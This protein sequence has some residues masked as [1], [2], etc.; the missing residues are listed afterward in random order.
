MKKLPCCNAYIQ[1]AHPGKSDEQQR[2]KRDKEGEIETGRRPL[3]EV[4]IAKVVVTIRVVVNLVVTGCNKRNLGLRS[5]G[6]LVTLVCGALLTHLLI[7]DGGQSAGNLLDL[8]AGEFLHEL[9]GEVLRPEG[10][11]RLLRVRGEQREEGIRQAGELILGGGLEQR[12]RGQIDGLGRV[13]AVADDDSLG[14]TTVTVHINVRKEI[15][16]VLKVGV[17]LRPA[18]ALAAL[19]LSLVGVKVRVLLGLSPPL[20]T[21]LFYPLR[22]GLFARRRGSLGLGLS[23]RRLCRLLALYLRIFGRIPRVKDLSLQKM[24]R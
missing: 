7:A 18:Q 15:R 23:F 21:V 8:L 3:H 14:R 1:K 13:G 9:A 2:K 19:G 12:H 5:L 16:G 22:L 11:L 4:I 20:V 24:M 10:I 17:L 6:L